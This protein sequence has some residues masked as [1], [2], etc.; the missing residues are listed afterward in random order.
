[1]HDWTGTVTH[2][3]RICY[4]SQKINLSQ[5]FAGQDVGVKQ[6]SD[7]IWLVTFMDYDLGLLRRR[8]LPARADREPIRPE[9]VTYVS[10]IIRYPCARNGPDWVGGE[11]GIRTLDTGFGPYNGLANRRL[12]PLGHL[13]ADGK[14]T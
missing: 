10:G 3:G 1:M 12:Q 13:T 7:R 8:D 5:V 6:V 9:S 4:K 14:C 11:A 2:C